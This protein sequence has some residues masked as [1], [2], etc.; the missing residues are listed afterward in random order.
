M[1][2]NEGFHR[3]VHHQLPASQVGI[4]A[5]EHRRF[6]DPTLVPGKVDFQTNFSLPAGREHPIKMG[7][8]AASVGTHL[9]DRKVGIPLILHNELM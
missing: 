3:S 8:G 6:A 7:D 1:N 4:V 9:G 5:L 2:V